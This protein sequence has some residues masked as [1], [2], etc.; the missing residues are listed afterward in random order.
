MTTILIQ[1]AASA[2]EVPGIAAIA[3]AAELRFTMTAEE[4]RAALPGAEV[5]L[6]WDFAAGG[7][8]AAYGI[9]AA[10]TKTQRAI[11]DLL[12]VSRTDDSVAIDVAVEVPQTALGKR[13]RRRQ[14]REGQGPFERAYPLIHGSILQFSDRSSW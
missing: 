6:G 1:G 4:L 2:K 5:L 3:D 9:L 7:L 13:G 11:D 10:V 14:D 8:H 12:D